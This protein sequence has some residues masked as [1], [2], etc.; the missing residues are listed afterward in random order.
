MVKRF[1]NGKGFGEGIDVEIVGVFFGIICIG[2]VRVK[3]AHAAEEGLMC[4]L[5]AVEVV[6]G[7]VGGPGGEVALGAHMAD[8]VAVA[9]PAL[10]NVGVVYC[11]PAEVRGVASAIPIGVG[12]PFIGVEAVEA[13]AILHFPHVTGNVEFAKE[14]G[15]VSGFAQVM[16][17]E[18]FVLG[19]NIVQAIDAMAGQVFA[20]PEAGA[21]GCA[22]RVVDIAL[23]VARAFTGE[24]VEVGGV[25]AAYTATTEGV[26]ALLVGQDEED[27]VG[28]EKSKYGSV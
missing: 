4:A 24:A 20:G 27:V 17:K 18:D 11:K 15:V 8:A 7:A 28:H 2:T 13:V 23:V 19:Q 6:D 1:I 3:D 26:P 25:Y 21:T 9:F 12:C 5:H 16:G 22:Y 10:E 14:R